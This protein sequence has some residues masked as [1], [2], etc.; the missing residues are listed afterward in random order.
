MRLVNQ[1][2]PSWPVWAVHVWLSEGLCWWTLS[3]TWEA[4]P[5]LECWYSHGFNFYAKLKCR[6]TFVD[7]STSRHTLI[8][9]L[10]PAFWGGRAIGSHE[11]LYL[12]FIHTKIGLHSCRERANDGNGTLIFNHTSLFLLH[13]QFPFTPWNVKWWISWISCVI[14]Q[15][16]LLA[17]RCWVMDQ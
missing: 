15:S 12:L 11:L 5:H 14:N 17:G 16:K 1:V 9:P 10:Q 7:C 6:N 8:W 4:D 2:P 13:V 3:N